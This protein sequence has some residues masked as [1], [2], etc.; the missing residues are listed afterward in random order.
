VAID[1]ASGKTLWRYKMAAAG[2]APP[3]TFSHNGRQYLCVIATGGR[4]HN[5]VDRAGKLYIF[6]L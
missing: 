2:S 3:I 6:A 5:F 4:F 1:A